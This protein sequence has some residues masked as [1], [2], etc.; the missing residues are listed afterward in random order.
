[1]AQYRHEIKYKLPCTQKIQFYL[2]QLEG[3]NRYQF[4]IQTEPNI[5]IH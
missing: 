4:T 3:H 2:V 1:M 5:G